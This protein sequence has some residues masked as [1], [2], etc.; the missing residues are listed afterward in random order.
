MLPT[1]VLPQCFPTGLHSSQDPPQAHPCQQRICQGRL[2]PLLPSC[3]FSETHMNPVLNGSSSHKILFPPLPRHIPAPRFPS[4]SPSHIYQPI[5]VY[6]DVPL[7]THSSFHHQ[8][9]PS[10][11]SCPLPYLQRLPP[12]PC[13]TNYP[14]P[15]DFPRFNVLGFSGSIF[16][17]PL[18]R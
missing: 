14:P 7:K 18:G 11:T 12:T 13:P 6:H 4:G 9:S 3:P 10:E 17:P 15:H 8:D 16:R 5:F 2:A 1:P